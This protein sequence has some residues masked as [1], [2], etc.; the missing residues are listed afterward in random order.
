[1]LRAGER[2]GWFVIAVFGLG[3]LVSVVQLLPNASYLLLT[4]RGFTVRSI[5]RS[6]FV[7]WGEIGFFTTATIATNRMVVFN[8]SSHFDRAMRARQFARTLAGFDGALP[9]TYGMRAE[10]LATLL[11][12][13]RKR[14]AAALDDNRLP[15]S[16]AGSAFS[17]QD[18]Q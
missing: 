9:D 8:Y 11:N 2:L 13:W 6:G 7:E 1:M 4:D 16:A 17:N 14:H 15:S 18:Q 10:D 12:D 5:Y 3:T